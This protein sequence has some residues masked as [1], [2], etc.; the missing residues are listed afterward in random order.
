MLSFIERATQL[1]IRRFFRRRRRGL[2]T[3]AEQI[4]DSFE[5]NVLNRAKNI[6]PVWRFVV[7]WL[8]LV[9]LVAGL[10]IAQSF[11]LAKLYQKELPVTGGVY[12]E[13]MLGTFSNANPLYASSAVDNAVSR[14]VFS[15]LM[16]YN[17]SN[18]LTTDLAKSMDVDSTGRVYTLT[19]RDN[20]RW[21]DGQ[22]LTVDDVVFTYKLIQNPDADSALRTSWQ[23]IGVTKL[24]ARTVRFTLP[25]TLAS[26]KYSLTTGIVPAH[27][28]SKIPANELRAHPFNT[29]EPVGAGPYAWVGLDLRDPASEKE[30]SVI[31]LAPYEQF[32]TGKPG[33]ER[34][35]I[36]TY[37]SEKALINAFT[38]NEVTAVAGLSKKP[39]QFNEL[40]NVRTYSF[41]N[42]AAVMVFFKTTEGILADGKVRQALVRAT[43]RTDFSKEIASVFRPISAPLLP[44]QVGYDKTYVQAPYNPSEAQ[45]IL[46]DAGW[47]KGSNGL[48]S[49]DGKPL[50]VRLYGE[51]TTDNLVILKKLKKSWGDIGVDVRLEAQEKANFQTTMNFHTYDAVLYGISLGP[52][53]DV[54]AY[55]HSTQ[56]DVRSSSRLNFSEYKSKATDASLEGGRTRLEPETRKVKYQP[57]L[58][59][60]QEDAPAVAL[61]QPRSFYFVRGTVYGLKNQ[62]INTD[63]DRYNN[64]ANWKIHTAGVTQ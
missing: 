60:W 64:A 39:A 32:H 12:T 53:P 9:T 55:W 44:D 48:R 56:A 19:L 59:A 27:I 2:E 18:Q 13:G 34:L 20:L 61:Y 62:V 24:D 57:F 40:E 16:K 21:H 11:G 4:D 63:A 49:K 47:S 5:H 54:Y 17:E 23:G 3:V 37:A 14:L 41:P 46:D 33:L 10:T 50:L 36:Q 52:D 28:L 8:G 31:A 22:P 1:R 42:T 25:S 58:K 35:L 26:F 38:Q 43:Y 29:R 6:L 45:K 30:T 51:E 7:G 15:G